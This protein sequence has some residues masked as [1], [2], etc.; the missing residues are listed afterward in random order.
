MG[1]APIRMDYTRIRFRV[2]KS[3]KTSN[4]KTKTHLRRQ[5]RNLK[6]I[7]YLMHV[8]FPTIP[9]LQMSKN[10]QNTKRNSVLIN[11]KENGLIGT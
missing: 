8:F 2:Y 3:N 11:S 5:I 6:L 10:A 4:L 7:C 1:Y 9:L